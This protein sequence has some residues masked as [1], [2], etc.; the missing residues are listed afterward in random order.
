MNGVGEAPWLP[1]VLG[2]LSV[3]GILAG[4]LLR[5]RAFLYLGTSFLLVAL[6]TIIWH[7]AVEKEMTWIW[8][9]CGIV[10]GALIITLFGVFEKKR[11]AM[12]QLV[13][14]VRHWEA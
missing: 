12:L 10:A 1:I 8:W 11:L 2:A 14:K 3:G 13:E 6:F 4:I 9:I 5:V 7:A